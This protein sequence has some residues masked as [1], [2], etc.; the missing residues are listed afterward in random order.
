MHAL[1]AHLHRV[2]F[3]LVP[4]PLG[5]DQ[6]GR[7][8]QSFLPGEVHPGWPDPLPGWI[9]EDETTLVAAAPAPNGE[10]ANR[11]LGHF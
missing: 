7:A 10:I 6:Q 9:F 4:E 1:L 8:V 5:M 3:G 11:A 2:G